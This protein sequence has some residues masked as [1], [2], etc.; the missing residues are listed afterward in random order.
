MCYLNIK[1]CI[2]CREVIH[3]RLETC[4]NA[5]ERYI[6]VDP[7]YYDD[8]NLIVMTRDRLLAVD[9]TRFIMQRKRD[10]TYQRCHDIG[11]ENAFRNRPDKP[12]GEQ[13][14]Y[15]D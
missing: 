11:I 4:D 1:Y 2:V 9:L 3:R 5:K 14:Y 13:G 6:C 15:S 8:R 12:C 7:D 10:G